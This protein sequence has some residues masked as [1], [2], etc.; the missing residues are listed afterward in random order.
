MANNEEDRTLLTICMTGRTGERER[1]RER[2]RER[3]RCM[4]KLTD[5]RCKP[6]RLPATRLPCDKLALNIAVLVPRIQTIE[7]SSQE[8]TRNISCS[9]DTKLG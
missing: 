2:G 6:G 9:A 1:E 3:Y 5:G 7:N 8:E 4:I